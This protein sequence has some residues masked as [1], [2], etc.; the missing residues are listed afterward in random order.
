MQNN[1]TKISQLRFW[2]CENLKK[3]KFWENLSY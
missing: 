1:C 2:S 3:L